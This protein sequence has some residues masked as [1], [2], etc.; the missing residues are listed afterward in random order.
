MI[1]IV[2]E[3]YVDRDGKLCLSRIPLTRHTLVALLILR[4]FTLDF[5]VSVALHLLQAGM[6]GKN[7][8]E[9]VVEHRS[10][11]APDISGTNGEIGN[12]YG[13]YLIIVYTCAIELIGHAA[14][15]QQQQTDCRHAPPQ[16]AGCRKSLSG[17]HHV[18]GRW[19]S[20]HSL[21]FNLC[22]IRTV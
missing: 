20:F 18:A 21:C 15:C 6:V 9:L 13:M 19:H 4:D 5:H 8:L 17:L 10:H 14:G 12:L 16:Q 7:I 11:R 22:L 3:A 1:R 2:R